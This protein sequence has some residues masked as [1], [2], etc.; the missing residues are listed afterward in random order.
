MA[1]KLD[2]SKS[3]KPSRATAPGEMGATFPL[4]TLR[5]Q[6]DRLFDDFMSD[7]RL[8]S[9]SR[10]LFSMPAFQ[11]QG[12]SMVDV[13]FDVSESDEGI[14][15]TAELPGMA[16]KDVEIALDD[17]VLTIKG[18]KKF[19][20]ETKDRD[21][22]LSERRYGNFARSMRLPDSID[23]EHI[24]ANFDKGILSIMLPK[25]PEA[26]AQKKKIEISKG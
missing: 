13:R 12:E 24:R 7:W 26:K 11:A 18:E 5:T 19:E 4:M 21:Y 15:V 17:G 1:S 20:K 14:E 8:P 9:L 2:I 10:D 22:H 25:R 3:R 23:Q 6:M 16:E